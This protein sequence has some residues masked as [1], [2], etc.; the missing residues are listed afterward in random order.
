MMSGKALRFWG[1][2]RR[3]LLL[4]G[5]LAGL[6]P[7]GMC[8]GL[9]RDMRSDI[10]PAGAVLDAPVE[11]L[12]VTSADGA[13]IRG[14]YLP[15][16]EELALVI[17]CHGV[18]ANRLQMLPQAQFLARL[19]HPVVL[20]DFRNHGRSDRA[21]TSYGAW[22]RHDIAALS[23]EM[24]QRLPRRPQVLWGLSLGATTALL[25][26]PELAPVRG[27]IAE[28]PFDTL[29]DTFHL[30]NRLYIHLPSWP[31]VPLT[32]AALGWSAGFDPEQ[33]APLE[34][35]TRLR[36]PVL[37]VTSPQ[38]RRMPPAVVQRV[39]SRHIGDTEVFTGSG[40]HA[41]IFARSGVPYRKRVAQFLARASQNRRE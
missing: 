39:A 21:R 13:V 4:L 26:A 2:F 20:F 29:R 7:I 41:L 6:V 25:A 16:R 27:V 3:V 17:L 10:P 12:T 8:A 9:T 15:G 30:H 38:D 35:V 1:I 33:V 28:S 18:G 36:A 23:A 40:P 22:E 19:G 34:A 14:W 11:E 31:F 24:A 37:F 5:L 32:L